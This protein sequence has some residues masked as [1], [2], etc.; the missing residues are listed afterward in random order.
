MEI[1]IKGNLRIQ[2]NQKDNTASIISSPEA[3]GHVFIPRF[4]EHENIKYKIIS[5]EDCAFKGCNIELLTF[6]EDSEIATFQDR[7]F[8]EA[9]IKKLGIPGSL[10]NLQA[11][12]HLHDLKEIEIS[13]KNQHFIFYN[14][15]FLLSKSSDKSDKFDVLHFALYDIEEVL[16]PSQV[17][18]IKAY[19]FMYHKK[20]KSVKFSPNSELKCIENH[21]FNNSSIQSLSLPASVEQIGYMCFSSTFNL[22]EIKIS[23]ENKKFKLIKN[24][25]VAQASDSGVFD[26]IIFSRR[27]ID[28]IHIPSYIKTINEQAFVFCQRLK[29]ITFEGNSSLK[30]IR[31]LAFSNIPGPEKLVIPP[32]LKETDR[33]SFSDIKNTKTFEFL[34]KSVIIKDKC[35]ESC[36]NLE[37]VI[38]TNAEEVVFDSKSLQF[39][40]ESAKIFVK[41]SAKLSGSGLPELQSRISYIESENVVEKDDV[42]KV[43]SESEK[44]KELTA[45]L[46]KAEEEISKLKEDNRKLNEKVKMLEEKSDTES[47]AKSGN[48]KLDLFD[49]EEIDSLKVV[50]TIGRGSQSEVFE[51]T[52]EQRLALKVLFIEGRS[53]S[54][55]SS[56]HFKQLHRF[57]QE[58]E[59]LSSLHHANIVKAF[60]FCYGDKSHAPSILLEMCV[61]NLND[62]IF[63]M[64]NIEKVCTI[65]EICQAM[66]AVHAANMIHSDLKPENVLFDAEGHVKISDFGVACIVNIDDQTQSKTSAVGTPKFM[67]PEILNDN[68]KYD[69]KVDVYSFGIV[70]FFILSGGKMPKISISEQGKKPQIPSNINKVSRQLINSC[71]STSPSE[72]PSFTEILDTIKKNK[73]R[74]IDGV[75]KNIAAI[76][77]FVKRSYYNS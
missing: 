33:S 31:S 34:A 10:Q 61:Q 25:Y 62:R 16:I 28:S 20:L 63:D 29:N 36:N 65:I 50:R 17:K 66:E 59:M 5:I 39:T 54:D 75:E 47:A 27:D 55:N 56:S 24:K 6:A 40:P 53:K 58:Y 23:P 9:H 7:C 35:F 77:S 12:W 74:L 46:L 42:K 51:V 30:S 19:S 64:N 26:E 41:R 68:T 69:N 32:S 11:M 13:P 15:Q 21:A 48:S 22:R 18:V 1:K 76:N 72:R 60:G 2:I 8:Y 57:L 4:A 49:P 67:A 37:K 45:K 38:F 52:R 71:W 73:F 43:T 3:S 44:I 70:L 14:K